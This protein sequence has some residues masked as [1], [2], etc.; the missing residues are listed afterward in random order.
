MGGGGGGAALIVEKISR[1]VLIQIFHFVRHVVRSDGHHENYIE[2][3]YRPLKTHQSPKATPVLAAVITSIITMLCG[4]ALFLLLVLMVF[5]EAEGTVDCEHENYTTCLYYYICIIIQLGAFRVLGIL[6]RIQKSAT[7]AQLYSVVS[8]VCTYNTCMHSR[9]L[10]FIF[11]AM[12]FC[13]L[14][15]IRVLFLSKQ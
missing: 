7:C 12:L 2:K 8:Y 14:M 3:R 13:M 5:E 6:T 1:N 10:F 4:S 9:F 15:A 11:F